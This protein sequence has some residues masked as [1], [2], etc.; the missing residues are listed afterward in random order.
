LIKFDH[1]IVELTGSE[2]TQV[3]VTERAILKPLKVD[4]SDLDST[5]TKQSMVTMETDPS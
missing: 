3:T 2:L 1:G 4:K 5:L